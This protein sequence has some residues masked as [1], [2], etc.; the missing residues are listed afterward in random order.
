MLQWCHRA[1]RWESV[2]GSQTRC[3]G[4]QE[5]PQLLGRPL[6]VWHQAV[7]LEL[8][9][10][11]LARL[12]READA[13]VPAPAGLRPRLLALRPW[14][15]AALSA[16]EGGME[17]GGQGAGALGRSGCLPTP[18]GLPIGTRTQAAPALPQDVFEMRFAK[19]PDEPAE[20]PAL[21]A[22]AA[23]VVSKGVESSRSSDESSSDSG[24]S[25]SEEERATRLAELQEQVSGRAGRGAQVGPR[26]PRPLT[27]ALPQPLP[28]PQPQ[29]E[30]P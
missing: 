6:A 15:G 18:R 17:G 5:G 25:D 3:L 27:R 9:R 28:P 19:M 23:P 11:G 16:W 8:E 1:E 10:K 14:S 24:S 20:A 2:S 29:P 22:P 12:L 26:P 4:A 7:A 21:P 13:W 30:A